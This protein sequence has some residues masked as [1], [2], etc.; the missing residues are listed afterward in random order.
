M[1]AVSHLL[2]VGLGPILGLA[3]RQ[4][5]KPNPASIQTVLLTFINYLTLG[6]GVF[7]QRH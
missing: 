1:K 5:A 2:D 6:R 4:Q 7:L 3:V